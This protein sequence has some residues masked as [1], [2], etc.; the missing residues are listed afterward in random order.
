MMKIPALASASVSSGIALT[1]KRVT[2][3]HTGLAIKDEVI[4]TTGSYIFYTKLHQEVDAEIQV[5][6]VK[7]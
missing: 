3:K 2:S 7:L 6:V 1:V 4:K 5:D